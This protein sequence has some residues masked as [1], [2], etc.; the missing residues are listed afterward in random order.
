MPF[1][2]P[3]ALLALLV[4]PPAWAGDPTP[5]G[6]WT[7]IDEVTGRPK[8][9]IRITEHQ[10]TFEGRIEK[11]YRAPDQDPDP[12]CEQCEGSRRNQPVV[13]MVFISGLKKDGDEYSGGE[14]V[15]PDN[16][17]VYRSSIRL[18]EGGS[19]LVVRGYI[20]FP[21][22]GRSETWVRQDQ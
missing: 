12:R 7:N 15:D 18:L 2:R 13:G 14:I 8:A 21:L 1:I 5:V 22:L 17:K 10:G 9:L 16:G 19:H 6:L 3:L 20:G 4:L 11:L